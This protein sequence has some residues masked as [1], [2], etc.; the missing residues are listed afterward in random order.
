MEG[1]R[2][3]QWCEMWHV[4]HHCSWRWAHT[5]ETCRA[6]TSSTINYLIQLH[7]VDSF[8]PI[9][10]M[11]HGYTNLKSVLFSFSYDLTFHVY[12]KII[13]CLALTAYTVCHQLPRPVCTKMRYILPW[14]DV[15]VLGLCVLPSVWMTNS[16]ASPVW[17]TEL[18]VRPFRVH[19]CQNQDTNVNFRRRVPVC[20]WLVIPKVMSYCAMLLV[21]DGALPTLSA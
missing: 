18:P 4:S 10:F 21:R 17:P 11:M 13:R 9:V 1:W 19:I 3:Q 8:T 20:W 2:E 5:P 15:S 16:S 12:G 7:Q 6:I 14:C